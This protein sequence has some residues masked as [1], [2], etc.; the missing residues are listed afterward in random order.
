MHKKTRIISIILAVVMI[1]AVLTAVGYAIDWNGTVSGGAGLSHDTTG[2]KFRV[3]AGDTTTDCVGYR[4]SVI[5]ENGDTV[6][7]AIDVFRN[8]EA[9]NN[10][11]KSVT[12]YNKNQLIA[13]YNSGASNLVFNTSENTTRCFLQ[14]SIIRT[15]G[16]AISLPVPSG[17][18]TWQ[19]TDL[20]LNAILKK[21]GYSTG[22][23]DLP[24]NARIIVE[25]LWRV[26]MH[27][28][29]Q[30]LTVS[31]MAAYGIKKIG[32]TSC[33]GSP[34]SAT[35]IFANISYYTNSLWPNQLVTSATGGLTNTNGS[36]IWAQ[37]KKIDAENH[38][39]YNQY[40]NGGYGG[41]RK[42]FAH[43]LTQGYG[44]GIAY[45]QT[46]VDSLNL[47]VMARSYSDN[48]TEHN[49][50]TWAKVVLS[51]SSSSYNATGATFR[52]LTYNTNTGFFEPTS[53]C[54]A[55]TSGTT[56]YIYASVSDENIYNLAYTGNYV[57]IKPGENKIGYVDFY[58]VSIEAC[59]YID[60]VKISYQHPNLST[61][62]EKTY[63]NSY[64]RLLKNTKMTYT[65]NVRANTSL[66]T[67]SFQK[68]VFTN[69]ATGGTANGTTNPWGYS[70]NS[71]LV[72]TRVAGVKAYGTRTAVPFTATFVVNGGKWSNNTTS[73]KTKTYTHD[74][75]LTA[76]EIPTRE[77]CHFDYWEVTA[78]DNED[79]WEI[80]EHFSGT[81][82]N[83]TMLQGVD[84]YT[85]NVTFTAHWASNTLK[86]AYD[87]YGSTVSV[88]D[89]SKG[90]ALASN[91]RI[92]VASG[93]PSQAELTARGRRKGN[94]DGTGNTYYVLMK[95]NAAIGTGGLDDWADFGISTPTGYTF[96][97]WKNA[98]N[99]KTFDQTTTTYKPTD[100][101]DD[102]KTSNAVVWL[103][104]QFSPITYYVKYY[105]NNT[106][107][108]SLTQT[109][110]YDT[111]YTYK[112]LPTP[113]SG[114]HYTASTWSGYSSGTYTPGGTFKNLASTQGASV[115]RYVNTTSN[116][117]TI[118]FKLDDGTG[119]QSKLAFATV[120]ALYKSDG[121]KYKDLVK[122]ASTNTY[123]LSDVPN[124]TY[125][126]Y[127]SLSS[128]TATLGD[129]GV[130]VTVNN[131]SPSA[132][133]N[134]YSVTTTNGT[135][136]TGA[137]A[138]T[139]AFVRGGANMSINATVSTGYTWSKWTGT[140]TSNGTS[141]S[142]STT[143]KNYTISSINAKWVLQATAT[144]NTYAIEYD[145]DGGTFASGLNGTRTNGGKPQDVNPTSA[146]YNGKSG[147][148]TW[149][150]VQEPTKTGYKFLGWTVTNLDSCTHHIW[151]ESKDNT[152]TLTSWT[153][154]TSPKTSNAREFYNLRSTSGTVKFKANWQANVVTVSILRSG[155]AWNN[156]GLTVKL[157]NKDDSTKEY[158][159]SAVSGKNTYTASKIPNGTYYVYTR[160]STATTALSS[161]GVSVTVSNNSPSATVKYWKIELT[162]GTGTENLTGARA[163]I[164]NGAS[165]AISA[166]ATTGY[167]WSKWTGTKGTASF[168]TTTNPYTI[169]NIQEDWKLTAT[170]TLNTYTANMAHW[171]Y[172]FK[173]EGTN[174]NKQAIRIASTKKTFNYGENNLS[175]TTSDIL[176]TLPNG[177]R[178]SP[179]TDP[180]TV[181]TYLDETTGTKGT[182]WHTYSLNKT[183]SYV[184]YDPSLQ[185]NYQLINYTITYDYDGGTAPAVSN[186]TS[187]NVVYGASFTNEPTRPG[188]TFAGWTID[189]KP[190]TGINETALPSTAFVNSDTV[191]ASAFTA[192]VKDRTTGNKTVKATWNASGVTVSILRSGSAW[193]NSGLTVKLV[194]KNDTTKEYPMTAVSGK[195]TYTVSAVPNGTYLVYTRI[196]TATTALSSSGVQVTVNNNSPSATVKY[197]KVE[198]TAGTGTENLTGARAYIRNGASNTINCDVISGYTW[199]KWTG[200]KGTSSFET[201][202]KQYT[203]T[204][205]QEDW[206]LTATATPN[207]YKVKY[208]PNGG[209]G[210]PADQ[211]KTHGVDL[212]LASGKPV[213]DGSV[214]VN[215]NTKADGT[216]STY[217]PGGKYT[218]NADLTL[219]AQWTPNTVT[220]AFKLDDGIWNDVNF[221]NKPAL[222]SSDGKTKI[223]DL[224]KTAG[225]NTYTARGIVNGTYK[226]YSALSSSNATNGDSGVTVTVNY[227]NPSSTVNYY[228]VTTTSGTGTSGAEAYT[229]TF[230]RAGTNYT[231]NCNVSTGYK[232]SKWTG[233]KIKNGTSTSVSSTTKQYTISNIQEK[234]VLQATSTPITY[235]IRFNSNGGTGTMADMTMTYDEAKNLT[236]NAFSKSGSTAKT[237]VWNTKADGSGQSYSDKQSVKN[238]SSTDGA[239]VILYAQ[240]QATVDELS[241]VPV[242]PNADYRE[243]TDVITAFNIVNSSATS[244]ITSSAVTVTFNVYKQSTVIKTVTMNNVVVPKNDQN[245]LYFKWTVPTGINANDISVTGD[246]T[247]GGRT[248]G[249]V[250]NTYTT[251]KSVVSV[252]PEPDYNFLSKPGYTIPAVPANVTGDATWSV[253]KYE[254][255]AFKKYTYG[256]TLTGTAVITPD[257]NANSWVSS[258]KT[259]TRSGYGLEFTVSGATATKSGTTAPEAA[260]YTGIQYAIALVPEFT[261]SHTLNEYRSLEKVSGSFVLPKDDYDE[262]SHFTT[263]WYPDGDYTVYAEVSD[264]WTPAGMITAKVA[265]N[266]LGIVGTVYDD[267]NIH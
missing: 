154:T 137:D 122:G 91:N 19:K 108:D 238:L 103:T 106:L 17:I 204:N 29:W 101:T 1:L 111:S 112:A 170:A 92:I 55:A 31:E 68:F 125:K 11:E 115:N 88:T 28:Y 93:G 153:Y 7:N 232:W 234:W 56:Y 123:T 100:F 80:G 110:K 215:W 164:R 12:K 252:T 175:I 26:V 212:T 157:V 16:T 15:D 179:A 149:F 109:C 251:T 240:W 136:I 142:V 199:S 141:S 193:N 211:T 96:A 134:Y 183:F 52:D 171:L 75:I 168:E 243:G 259:Y 169:T 34:S 87:A 130:S 38:D 176:S 6:A 72:A 116:V 266:A 145:L 64:I 46:A 217:T 205:I 239:I 118:T 9:Y 255:G 148:S 138:Y 23:S 151:F 22:I 256:L 201:A 261:Y 95:Y 163:Y 124:G 44:V 86:V 132:T 178:R 162:A 129:S 195:N 187:Y 213:K 32:A 263:L 247:E 202:T 253:W 39:D 203:I 209:S 51:T 85:G 184:Q 258:G 20:N 225:S 66:Y 222:Y 224:N 2:A 244:R 71:G 172:G 250:S 120:P 98:A 104:A 190:A 69:I 62:Y 127:S 119:D 228:S 90:F 166:A 128:A 167:T 173:T 262:R 81:T 249:H 47:K 113:P 5:N 13:Q 146:T 35:S 155:T 143:T 59:S 156:S 67:Y 49:Y 246:I 210:A 235:T 237:P 18:E 45:T 57:T 180:Y 133:V 33:G 74:D 241:L 27:G 197:W 43:I 223:A 114:K 161:S 121:T 131:N 48:N 150:Y 220:I 165:N 25:P 117:V 58:K 135:G 159:M 229:R 200:T 3:N 89:S 254:S 218:G 147:Q 192:A 221:T 152:N 41:Y 99:G 84:G 53:R 265:S 214:F 73:N 208:D 219:Y 216:G 77:G 194:N 245:L 21:L 191:A 230:I 37:T 79:D 10:Y 144:P 97:N 264:C 198:L 158:T 231:I 189:G 140:K 181:G 82:S 174:S 14:S 260:A 207:T 63:T 160:I 78:S 186:P 226:I 24:Y 61:T 257:E 185:F 182:S 236:A 54:Y 227:N 42:T 94:I 102:I 248:Y 50:A 233:N 8:T 4:F 206:K 139:R 107:Q 36:K 70:N 267:W 126:I 65:A 76:P 40:I 242:I 105:V 188:Y 30:S 83:P 177:T 196:S 60:S